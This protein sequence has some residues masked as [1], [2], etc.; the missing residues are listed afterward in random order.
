MAISI[1]DRLAIHDLY[2]TWCVTIDDGDAV[3]WA[4]TFTDDATFKLTTHP[5]EAIGRDAILEMGKSVYEHDQGLNRHLCYNI[6]LTEDGDAIRG[7]A[8]AIVLELR[9][10]GDVR[11][12]KTS[13]YAD[14]IV[15]GPKGW[16]FAE[17][18]MTW[19][20][21]HIPEQPEVEGVELL[22]SKN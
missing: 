15:K 22:L 16:A 12:I 18:V 3:A 21:P 13:R 8:D 10:G 2:S 5:V 6:L 17:R 19:D 1:E 14:R 4:D 9:T 11:I 20:T 7:R